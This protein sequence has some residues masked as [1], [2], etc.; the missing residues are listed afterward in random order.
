MCTTLAFHP[1]STSVY[2]YIILGTYET[3]TLI[4]K[5]PVNPPMLQPNSFN[6]N[7]RIIHKALIDL[8]ILQAGM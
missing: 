5:K 6:G 2:I 8:H 4:S 7:L 3:S 1:Y